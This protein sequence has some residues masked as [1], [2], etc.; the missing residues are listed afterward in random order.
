MLALRSYLR[1]YWLFLFWTALLLDLYFI[2]VQISS[3]RYITKPGL[4]IFL[5]L[6]FYDSIKKYDQTGALKMTSFAIA[7]SWLGDV[8]LLIPY[9]Q[10]LLFI[11]GLG[12]FLIAHL[13]YIMIFRK[14][15]NSP[16][17]RKHPNFIRQFIF[18]LPILIAAALIYYI[19]S[20]GLGGMKF[21]VIIYILT[22]TT[23]AAT[24]R[25]RFSKTN[26]QSFWLIF[27]GAISFMVSDAL[28]AIQKF[29]FAIAY[30][31]LWVMGTYGLA[32]YLLIE[33]IIKHRRA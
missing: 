26:A 12:A 28:L 13:L 24:A 11:F 19:I 33:G 3:F 21:P 22:I 5:G 15:E 1:Y 23:M 27:L 31:Q 17:V 9:R 4:M 32:Q 7:F 6:Y 25:D 2:E 14:L 29:S 20:P 30:G 8:F 10:D 18:N 16:E